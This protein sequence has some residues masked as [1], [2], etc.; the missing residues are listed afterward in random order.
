MAT[1]GLW[2]IAAEQPDLVAV[3]DPDGRQVTY[4]ELAA[5]ADRYGRGF[6]AM[7]LRPGD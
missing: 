5:A 6:Q 7:G 4:G 1:I 3:V 2:N